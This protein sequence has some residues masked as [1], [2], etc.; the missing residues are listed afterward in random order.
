MRFGTYD[1]RSRRSGVPRRF[2]GIRRHGG[3]Y[4]VDV[5]VRMRGQADMRVEARIHVRRPCCGRGVPVH[6]YGFCADSA[7]GPQAPSI[8]LP[9]PIFEGTRVS[10]RIAND[11]DRPDARDRGPRASASHTPEVQAIRS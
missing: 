11:R 2:H 9:P 7:A 1:L 8:M 3:D 4:G 6:T 10:L 5:A